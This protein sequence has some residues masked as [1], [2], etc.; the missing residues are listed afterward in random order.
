MIYP[1]T[2]RISKRKTNKTYKTGRLK[3]LSDFAFPLIERKLAMHNGQS[4]LIDLENSQT[5]LPVDYKAVVREATN[6]FITIFC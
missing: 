4:H 3:D 2:N 6:E 1:P 5:F